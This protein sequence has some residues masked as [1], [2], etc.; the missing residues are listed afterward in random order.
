MVISATCSLSALDML[1]TYVN[2]WTHMNAACAMKDIWKPLPVKID[3]GATVS[4]EEWLLLMQAIESENAIARL[5]SFNRGKF[6]RRIVWNCMKLLFQVAKF[7]KE[8]LQVRSSLFQRFPTSTR[9]KSSVSSHSEKT[10]FAGYPNAQA[11]I[12]HLHG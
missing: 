4:F 6:N 3:D 8:F 12:T 2:V 1:W 10:P 7:Y 11:G 5:G 9:P